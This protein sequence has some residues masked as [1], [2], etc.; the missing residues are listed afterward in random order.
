MSGPD[1]IP[2]CGCR[3]QVGANYMLLN[4][5]FV[6]VADLDV[7]SLLDRVRQEVRWS[8]ISNSSV[9]RG[10]T[11]GTADSKKPYPSGFRV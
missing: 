1:L 8:S 3:L 2:A 7:F 5:Q 10:D 4:G 6:G 11:T 9:E